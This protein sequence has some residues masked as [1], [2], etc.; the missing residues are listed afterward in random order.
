MAQQKGTIA[1]NLGFE[2]AFGTPPATGVQ[3]LVNSFGLKASRA[4]NQPATLTPNR[5]PVMPFAGNTICRGAVVVPVDSLC[6]PHWLKAMFGAPVTTG[7]GPYVHEFK[8]GDTQPSVTLEVPFTRLAPAK[9]SRFVGCKIAGFSIEAGGDGELVMSLDVAGA[10]Q[11]FENASFGTPTVIQLARLMNMQAAVT[12]GGAT[13]A[14]AKLGAFNVDFGLDLTQYLMGTGGVL[15]AIPEGIPSVSGR[16][17]TLFEDTALLAK[18]QALTESGVK[19]TITG[20]ASSIFELECQEI[21]YEWTTPEVTGPQGMDVEAPFRAYY[22]NGS[23]QSAIVARLTNS[24][25]SYA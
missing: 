6:L 11:S 20:S 1:V 4:L 9:Y 22:D 24:V 5:N 19:V 16:L 14:N 21:L 23:K 17:R 2:N 7:S 12:E 13:L 8:I 3:V 10:N 15:G 18:G 25:P